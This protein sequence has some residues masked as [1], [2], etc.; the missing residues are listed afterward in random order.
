LTRM[1]NVDGIGS[2]CGRTLRQYSPVEV[3]HISARSLE[4]S[5]VDMD[6]KVVV[7]KGSRRSASL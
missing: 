2:A 4:A 5:T 6:Q 7:G 1:A 3:S